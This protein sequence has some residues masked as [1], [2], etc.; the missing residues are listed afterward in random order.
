MGKGDKRSFRGKI[1]IGSFGK[2]RPKRYT[3]Q[4]LVTTATAPVKK[5]AEA[6]VEVKKKVTRKTKPKEA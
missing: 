6:V 1:K 4:N 2:K 5:K 3:Q